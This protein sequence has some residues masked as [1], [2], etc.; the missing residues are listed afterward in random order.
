MRDEGEAVLGREF[1]TNL[2]SNPDKQVHLMDFHFPIT[3]AGKKKAVGAVVLDITARRQAEEALRLSEARYQHVFE[4]TPVSVW[5]QDCS[6]LGAALDELKQQG[7]QDFRRYFDEHPDF[8]H[9][10]VGMFKVLDVNQETL[11]M[12]GALSKD[13]ML[14]SLEKVF[15]PETVKVFREE[16]IAEIGRASCR[17]RV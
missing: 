5:E 12:F 1:T 10:A 15:V 17:E 2:P 16:L 7:V 9:R 6:E 8:V 3:V 14:A 13:Q 4:S 11:E